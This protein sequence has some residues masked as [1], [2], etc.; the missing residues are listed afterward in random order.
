VNLKQHELMR[1]KLFDLM[2]TG[3]PVVVG[4][5]HMALA[6][7]MR[8]ARDLYKRKC[9]PFDGAS[10]DLHIALELK[11]VIETIEAATSSLLE[12]LAT[13]LELAA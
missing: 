7:L 11:K 3:N 2:N 10:I 5:P 12:A 9:A 1:V 4:D 8:V 6:E 13:M